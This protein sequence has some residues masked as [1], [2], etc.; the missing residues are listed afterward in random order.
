MNKS[1]FLLRIFV[2]LI[3]WIIFLI[4]FGYPSLVNYLEKN[5][6]FVE[7]ERD[8]GPEDLPIIS[9]SKVPT[10]ENILNSACLNNP[11]GDEN[12]NDCVLRVTNGLNE[13]VHDVR[14][15]IYF[16]KNKSINRDLWRSTFTF[17]YWGR[18]FYLQDYNLSHNDYMRISFPDSDDYALNLHDK[19]FFI[20][21]SERYKDYKW[22]QKFLHKNQYQS[23]FVDITLIILLPEVSGCNSDKEYSF[24][25]CSKV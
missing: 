20:E 5:T 15:N 18:T 16:G 7:T 8:I 14:E 11:M 22:L 10:G 6:F 19:K 25:Q 21:N 3:L 23:L 9:V 24:L 2:C 12:V 17:N 4:F 1:I 13:T